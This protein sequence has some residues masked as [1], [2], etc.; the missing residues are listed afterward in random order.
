[1]F[2]K[3]FLFFD[4]LVILIKQSLI[5]TKNIILN[6][7]RVSF[8]NFIGENKVDDFINY[9]LFTEIEVGTPPQKVTH[10]ID[11][12]DRIFQFK[13]TEIRYNSNK[14]N[15]S[16]SKF[17]EN[18]FFLFN[19]SKSSSYIGSFSDNFIFDTNENEKIEVKKLNFTIYLNNRND[20]NKYGIIGLQTMSEN[21]GNSFFQELYSFI[22]QLKKFKYYFGL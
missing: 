1:M 20:V 9:D 8:E 16:V 12:N 5:N 10:F 3:H 15:N 18:R 2:S 14:F 17:F 22:N 7:N 19:S 11:S 21:Q 13:K 4:I 6:I